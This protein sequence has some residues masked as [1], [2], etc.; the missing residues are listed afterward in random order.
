[1]TQ[2]YVVTAQWDEQASV[3]VATSEDIP[4]LV[5]EAASLDLLYARISAVALEL[6]R[7]NG[8]PAE[9]AYMIDFHVLGP[10][11]RHAAE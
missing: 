3:W 1:M 6:L 2:K 8:T 5:S 10:F 4:G 9:A 7:D 11:D